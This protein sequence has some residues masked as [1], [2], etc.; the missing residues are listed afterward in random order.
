MH[1]FFYPPGPGGYQ[2]AITV[3][4]WMGH[5]RAYVD[6]CIVERR[7]QERRRKLFQDCL[8]RQENSTWYDYAVASPDHRCSHTHEV[9]Q[10]NIDSLAS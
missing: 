5:A 6:C 2:I 7:C 1:L 4:A 8:D 3:K 9:I 10:D